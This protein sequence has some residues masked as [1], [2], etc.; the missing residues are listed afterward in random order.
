MAKIAWGC[1]S[2]D[3][4]PGHRSSPDECFPLVGGLPK[5]PKRRYIDVSKLP[6]SLKCLIL[7]L[8]FTNICSS[9][10]W[11]KPPQEQ[12]NKVGNKLWKKS[13]ALIIHTFWGCWIQSI[14]PLYCSLPLW[15][16][17]RFK[18]VSGANCAVSPRNC[19]DRISAKLL[20]WEGYALTGFVREPR[21]LLW[22]DSML[23][24]RILGKWEPSRGKLGSFPI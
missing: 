1:K 7:W 5:P 2:G 11:H 21:R 17:R 8:Y 20:W 4:T 3:Q 22:Q 24:L 16:D 10:L 19:I 14:P 9:Y 15:G 18:A 23:S 13:G 6:S 12:K